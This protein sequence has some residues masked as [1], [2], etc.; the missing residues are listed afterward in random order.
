MRLIQYEEDIQLDLNLI[1]DEKDQLDK[2]MKTN[3]IEYKEF[4][5][6]VGSIEN[7]LI[8]SKENLRRYQE[9]IEIDRTTLKKYSV[10][11]QN[12]V[13]NL[14]EAEE[15]LRQVIEEFP[16]AHLQ[17]I[18]LLGKEKKSN[19]EQKNAEYQLKIA[20]EN[21]EAAKR[22]FDLGEEA[23][24]RVNAFVN[25]NPTTSIIGIDTKKR[26][27]HARETALKRAE[28]DLKIRQDLVLKRQ[29][30]CEIAMA[31]RIQAYKTL[32]NLENQIEIEKENVR[33]IKAAL[34]CL[35]YA[36]EKLERQTNEDRKV[37]ERAKQNNE[38]LEEAK[39][40]QS[41][42]KKSKEREIKLNQQE[43]NF[44]LNKIN[45][46]QIEL[47]AVKILK[48]DLNK[49]RNEMQEQHKIF[50]QSTKMST[51]SEVRDINLIKEEEI[52]QV[53][54][55]ISDLEREDN[56]LNGKQ[57]TIKALNGIVSK[58]IDELEK[59]FQD[60]KLLNEEIKKKIQSLEDKLQSSHI[61]IES[62]EQNIQVN[63]EKRKKF[64]EFLR[65]Q[66]QEIVLRR[67][68]IISSQLNKYQLEAQC[69]V[70]KS[71]LETLRDNLISLK[72]KLAKN[73][74][75]SRNIRIKIL[76]LQRTIDQEDRSNIDINYAKLNAKVRNEFVKKDI[77]TIKD[78]IEQLNNEFMG[79]EPEL[80]RIST[81][82]KVIYQEL[83]KYAR[84]SAEIQSK[85]LDKQLQINHSHHEISAKEDINRNYIEQQ[86]KFTIDEYIHYYPVS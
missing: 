52:R 11:Y 86:S 7:D 51:T 25:A 2:I 20:E 14:A 56:Q 58:N 73:E 32:E 72:E 43:L 13:R 66:T 83:F 29:K 22:S 36:M 70:A 39:E 3:Q 79:M 45:Q 62:A 64:E 71:Q 23:F 28:N 9:Q 81:Q 12:L 55:E 78:N 37:Y 82:L 5:D 60:E 57:E 31:N 26:M 19:E 77:S 40:S 59:V 16:T 30:D 42:E 47:K 65:N 69:K 44:L 8:K 10:E 27:F 46:K 74:R 17:L 48:E 49:Q 63:E 84:T 21:A 67:I 50:V 68:E 24:N 18:N 1:Q 41:N 4:E 61:G 35:E 53:Q 34:N 85:M 75:E 38:T 54:D 80:N 76:D 6:R 15:K 33:K